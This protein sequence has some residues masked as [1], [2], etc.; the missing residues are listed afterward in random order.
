MGLMEMTIAPAMTASSATNPNT[1]E[2]ES[3]QRPA[4]A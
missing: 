2:K 3:S 4:T 1:L